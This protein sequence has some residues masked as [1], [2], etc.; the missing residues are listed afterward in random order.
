MAKIILFWC[1]E[2]KIFLSRMM[3]FQVK[4]CHHSELRLWRTGMLFST[5]SKCHISNFHISWM[6]RCCFYDL[7]VYIWCLISGLKFDKACLNTLYVHTNSRGPLYVKVH[8]PGSWDWPTWL[9]KPWTALIFKHGDS[10][11]FVNRENSD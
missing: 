2:K 6:Y 7:K 8:L 10:Q 5:K 1:F 9:N 3:E 11:L 4:S